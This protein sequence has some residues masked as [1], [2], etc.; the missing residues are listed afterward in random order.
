VTFLLLVTFADQ[1][2][3]DLVEHVQRLVDQAGR[4]VGQVRGQQGVT[5]VGGEPSQRLRGVLAATAGELAQPVGVQ[6]PIGSRQL[7]RA[8]VGAAVEH[9]A[10][11]LGR[12]DLRCL[13]QPAQTCPRPQLGVDLDQLIQP[14]ALVNRQ[15]VQKPVFHAALGQTLHTPDE[16]LQRGHAGR[17][18]LL[19]P[20]ALDA[21]LDQW[22]RPIAFQRQ[23]QQ[24]LA[25][26]VQLWPAAVLETKLA[27]QLVEVLEDGVVALAV[28]LEDGWIDVNLLGD[29]LDDTLGYLGHVSKGAAG[30]S[31][32][33]EMDSEAETVGGSTMPTDDLEITG[34]QRVEAAEVTFGQ[35]GGMRTNASRCSAVNRPGVLATMRLARESRPRGGW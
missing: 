16:T 34:R 28:L 19:G 15:W 23:W 30:E 11:A 32:Q 1:L 29:V 35:I 20:Q 4:K 31:E 26:G 33:S 18:D 21:G 13:A 6:T 2:V 22:Q 3:K 7:E 10:Q 24:L 5:L 9:L 12:R 8:H 17:D 14:R 25:K 27:A